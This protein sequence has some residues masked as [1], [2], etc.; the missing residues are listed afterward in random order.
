MELERRIIDYP[1]RL[2]GRDPSNGHGGSGLGEHGRR[3]ARVSN[4]RPSRTPLIGGTDKV[5][6]PIEGRFRA[7]YAGR[8]CR[9]TRILVDFAHGL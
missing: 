6:R 8:R 7:A 5:F 3:Q 1:D 2:D 4:E 9:A